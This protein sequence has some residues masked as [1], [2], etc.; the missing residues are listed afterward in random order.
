MDERRDWTGCR[1]AVA[2]P[3]DVHVEPWIT[4][5]AIAF[6]EG[7]LKPE[8]RVL[9]HG[10]GGSTLWLAERVSEVV[11]VETNEKWRDGILARLGD[12]GLRDKVLSFSSWPKRSEALG[13]F[14]L[15]FIDGEPVEDR[16][17]ALG[18]AFDYYVKLGGWVVLDNFNHGS[19]IEAY[20]WA[21]GNRMGA[22]VDFWTDKRSINHTAFWHVGVL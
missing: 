2:D 8:F 3:K 5:L 1:A 22:E 17:Q 9:E 20:A 12:M 16:T 15:V 11:S 13:K 21:H 6:F 18:D 7:I 19:I 14:D 4:P 10:S